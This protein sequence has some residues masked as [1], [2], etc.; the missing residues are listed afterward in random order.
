MYIV[1]SLPAMFAM[2]RCECAT[3]GYC[4][5][6]VLMRKNVMRLQPY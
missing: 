5:G 6:A 3:S 4:T 2:C 1:A